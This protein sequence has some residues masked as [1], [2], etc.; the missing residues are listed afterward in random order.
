MHATF[1]IPQSH[2]SAD[3]TDSR[4]LANRPQTIAVVDGN[5]T[6]FASIETAMGA[7][8]H[9]VLLLDSDAHA[10]AD[11]RRLQ[12]SLVVLCIS[13]DNPGPVQLLTMLQM[14]SKTRSIPVTTVAIENDDDADDSEDVAAGDPPPSVWLN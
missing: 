2:R 11:I 5:T 10:Y 4:V 13:L 14:D 7:A 8:C 3:W 9:T 1:N 12:P 6:V